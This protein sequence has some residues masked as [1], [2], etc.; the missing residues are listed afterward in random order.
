MEV[1]NQLDFVYADPAPIYEETLRDLSTM[2]GLDYQ[3]PTP[4]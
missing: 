3:P 1:L 4:G 2:L